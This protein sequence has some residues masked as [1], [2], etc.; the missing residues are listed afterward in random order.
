MSG[1]GIIVGSII[2]GFVIDR[3]LIEIANAI[4]SHGKRP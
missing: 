3:G 2:L 1:L 4:R